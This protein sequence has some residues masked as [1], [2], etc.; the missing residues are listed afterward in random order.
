[1]ANV[2]KYYWFKLFDNFF[3]SKVVK[4]L[5]KDGKDDRDTYICVYLK[6]LLLS[7]A[8]QGTIYQE[9]LEETLDEELALI[10]NRDEEKVKEIIKTLIKIKAIEVKSEGEYFMTEVP[11]LIGSETENA[12]KMRQLRNKKITDYNSVITDDNNVT[13]CYD[14]DNN[15][16]TDDNNV[17]TKCNNVTKCYDGD[18]NVKNCYTDIDI[19]IDKE[20][21]TD[22]DK[23]KE[24]EIDTDS[25]RN[26]LKIISLYND[27]CVSL[28][29]VKKLSNSR[30]KAIR[31]RLNTY[32]F[33][34]FK[35]LFE[36]AEA[37][38]FLKGKN[39]S[40]WMADFDWLIKDSNF[41]KVLEGKYANYK[42]KPKGAQELEDFYDAVAD[43]AS[44]DEGGLN[45]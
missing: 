1:M 34:D 44:Q 39:N 36:L 35:S 2:K 8:N 42:K 26:Y 20:I 5:E 21:D 45:G 37:S 41:T 16:I 29:R 13:K 3:E 6:L 23:D 40:N 32:T 7:L 14:D 28:P 17:I 27:T 9:G 30:K 15:V 38:D 4:K 22:T 11:S 31:A 19:D 12:K 25:T 43:W 10:I 24:I 18:N 33:E